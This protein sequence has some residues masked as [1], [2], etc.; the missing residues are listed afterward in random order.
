[1][2]VFT[3]LTL[4]GYLQIKPQTNTNDGGLDLVDKTVNIRKPAD[5]RDRYQALG[6]WAVNE[7]QR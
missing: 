2:M 3:L 5:Y 6:T 7:S 4:A 1:M